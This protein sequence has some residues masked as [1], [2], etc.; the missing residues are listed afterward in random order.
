MRAEDD[1]VTH[2][3]DVR[4]EFWVDDWTGRA[5]LHGNQVE[6]VLHLTSVRE[7][8]TPQADVVSLRKL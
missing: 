1:E 8:R 2:N 7:A 6:P 3:L 4:T 5:L